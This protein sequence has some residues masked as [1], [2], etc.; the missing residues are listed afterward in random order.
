MKNCIL[1]F[2]SQ[3]NNTLAFFYVEN[4]GQLKLI[5]ITINVQGSAGVIKILNSSCY[6]L[7][8]ELESQNM[9]SF[10]ILA[11]SSNLSLLDCNFKNNSFSFPLGFIIGIGINSY[12]LFGKIKFEMNIIDT[13]VFY[14]TG[15]NQSIIFRGVFASQNIEFPILISNLQDSEVIYDYYFEVIQ[16]QKISNLFKRKRNCMIFIAKPVFLLANLTDI[17]LKFKAHMFFKENTLN[18]TTLLNVINLT[19]EKPIDGIEFSKPIMF[20]NNIYYIYSN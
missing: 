11:E 15:S 6:I 3:G 20:S 1:N 5:N 8:L 16:H 9:T 14:L 4:G 13:N 2:S 17:V 7:S 12:F 10:L 18:Q 19:N